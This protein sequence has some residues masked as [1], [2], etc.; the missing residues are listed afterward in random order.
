MA[1]GYV[2]E[3]MSPCLVLALLVP[4]KD[5]SFGTCV[6]SR[7]IN[8]IIIKY[9]YPILRLDDILDALHSYSIFSEIHLRSGYH[10][11]RMRDGD[12]WKMAFMTKEG[13]SKWLV[14][15]FGL[16]NAPSTFYEID[17]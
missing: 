6:D 16:S 15:P 14:M 12:G 9:R 1:K 8:N 10:Q 7:A 17:E 2:R 4:K 11:I 13:L 3:S 5:G